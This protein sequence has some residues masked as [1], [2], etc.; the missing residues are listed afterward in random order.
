MGT[1]GGTG[2][3]V[4][5]RMHADRSKS[6]N[7]SAFSCADRSV[8]LQPLGKGRV[9][10]EVSLGVVPALETWMSLITTRPHW[11]WS[12]ST[13]RGVLNVKYWTEGLCS[14]VCG[15]LGMASL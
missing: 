2:I 15:A 10:L 13:L 7:S 4:S 11:T 3:S 5:L 6:M 9:V 8:A 14:V 12:G 1:I